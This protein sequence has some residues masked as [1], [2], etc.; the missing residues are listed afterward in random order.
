MIRLDRVAERL[1]TVDL[2]TSS[3]SVTPSRDDLRLFQLAENPLNRPFRDSDSLR[4][5]PHADVR[6]ASDADQYMPVIAQEGP[7]WGAWIDTHLKTTAI[8]Y[9]KHE[10][11]IDKPEINIMLQES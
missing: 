11:C 8:L 4:D 7:G 6:I 2:V 5:L 3:A 1:V 9:I 10:S